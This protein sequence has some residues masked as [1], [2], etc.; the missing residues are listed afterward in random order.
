[1]SN[2]PAVLS[3]HNLTKTFRHQGNV[4]EAVKEVTLEVGKGEFVAIMGASGAG[5]STLLHLVAGLTLPDQGSLLINGTDLFN[6]SERRRTLFRRQHI[7][8]VFQAFNLLPALTGEENIVL[9]VLLG[10]GT[11][12]PDSVETLIAG[13][14][15]QSVIKRRPDAMSGGE[16]QRIAIGRAL[17]TEPS[18]VL[19]D[20]PTGSLD[21]ANSQKLCENF[22][23]LCREKGTTVLMVTHN[24][25]VAFAASKILILNDGR[26]VGTV[27][28]RECANVQELMARYVRMIDPGHQESAA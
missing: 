4:V 22:H 19:A 2:T 24:P 26:L 3:I 12:P 9:P 10:G 17:V 27:L 23:Y 18:L 28:K 11:C 14:G 20:E 15:L 16:Q 21:S 6:L 5:K 7:G 8:L 25:M 13:L 1:M